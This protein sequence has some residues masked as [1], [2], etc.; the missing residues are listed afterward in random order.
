MNYRL[1][2]LTE[3][4]DADGVALLASG[5]AAWFALS[6][7][8]WLLLGTLAIGGGA[9]SLWLGLCYRRTH[10]NDNSRAL[11]RELCRVHELSRAERR[12]LISLAT[13]LQLKA[14]CLLFIDSN[15]WGVPDASDQDDPS[16]D[17][18]WGKLRKLQRVLFSPSFIQ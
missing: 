10:R 13:R 4:G 12:L 7:W 3:L 2:L 6:M 8:T 5:F 18:N 11:F 17:L 14:P 15:L 9:F 16:E 1:E